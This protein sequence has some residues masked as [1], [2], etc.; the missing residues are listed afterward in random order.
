M[1]NDVLKQLALLRAEAFGISE[2]DFSHMNYSV[3]DI[4]DFYYSKSADFFRKRSEKKVLRLFHFAAQH[5]PAYKEFLRINSIEYKKI[6]T[7]EDFQHVP[8]ITKENYLSQFSLE[9]LCWNG[10]LRSADFIASSSGTT[11]D[12]FFWP[13]S[14]IDEIETTIHHELLLHTFDIAHKK[15]LIVVNY[16]F[17]IYVGG[18]YT[19]NVLNK[20]SH[21]DYPVNII[22]PGIDV[23]DSL[24]A[25]TKM[26][27][28]YDQV[29]F[30]GYPPIILDILKKGNDKIEWKSKKIQFIFSS[31]E[32]QLSFIDYVFDT[33]DLGDRDRDVI[34]MYACSDMAV[35]G[36][37]S[38]N[39]NSFRRYIDAH[40]H[41]REKLF[42]QLATPTVFQYNPLLKYIET[43]SSELI[44]SADNYIPLIRYNLHD[45]GVIYEAE[46]FIDVL[47]DNGCD[48]KI[49]IPQLP[50]LSIFGRSNNTVSLYGVNLYPEHISQILNTKEHYEHCTGNFLMEK[51][52]LSNFDHVIIL[53][54][55]M[56]ENIYNKK[57][58]SI[59]DFFSISIIEALEKQNFE[60]KKL[61]E[62]IG[63]KAHIQVELVDYNHEKFMKSLKTKNT[64][65]IQ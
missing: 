40:P 27:D 58:S 3:N 55:Q 21:R 20:M 43:I 46:D 6:Q 42:D 12:P 11:G 7:I 37:S 25:L 36:A 13:R 64:Y 4:N 30:I 34:S 35:I 8:I 44:I 33:F 54:I 18:I 48:E 50:I 31:E 60:F 2:Y 23:E 17:G 38:A 47:Q 5:V 15:T 45:R 14:K 59:Q 41:I 1:N 24:T 32:Q 65:V 29:I 28:I 16:G 49:D 9:E 63:T 62:K 26:I 19:M 39:L 61:R 52:I 53:F 56:K 57:I 10:T 51:K 22:S